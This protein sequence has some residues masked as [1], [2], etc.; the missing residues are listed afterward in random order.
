MANPEIFANQCL[1]SLR[2]LVHVIDVDELPDSCGTTHTYNTPAQ[3]FAELMVKKTLSQNNK[4][5]VEQN[6]EAT[7]L[8]CWTFFRAITLPYKC[9][10]S[11]LLSIFSSKLQAVKLTLPI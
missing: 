8:I 7:S 10:T 6:K 2:V 5:Q 11:A 3:W 4:E 9:N 1:D